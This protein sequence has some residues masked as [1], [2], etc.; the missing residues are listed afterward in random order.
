MLDVLLDLRLAAYRGGGIARYARELHAALAEIPDINAVALRTRRDTT[1]DPSALRLRTPP[2]HRLESWSVAT[3]IALSRTHIDAF[4]A[5]DFVA[6]HLP[7]TPSVATV[8]DLAFLDRPADL[9]PD[10]LRY[11]RQLEHSKHRTAAWITPSV[12][13]ADALAEHY[14]IECAAIHVIPH[15]VSYDL[16]SAP[17]VPS[18]ERGDYILAVGTIEPRKQYDLLLDALKLEP[19]LPRLIVAGAPG[20]NA[21]ATEARLRATPRVTWEPIVTDERLRDLYRNALAVAIP[22][23]AE[24]FGL[25]ALEAM[26]TGTPVISSGSGALPEVTGAVCVTVAHPT[27]EMWAAAMRALAR[28][29]AAWE[30]LSTSG[31]ERATHFTWQITAEQTAAVYRSVARG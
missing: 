21:S 19:T 2:H 7:G 25:P 20:W 17:V 22:S 11:Y 28:D 18:T 3:E 24:G 4:H 29:S 5:T 10:A 14:R 13:T 12:W 27:P 6:P 8:H 31:R 26:A 30:A 9:A 16:Q 23:R 1:V 15:G